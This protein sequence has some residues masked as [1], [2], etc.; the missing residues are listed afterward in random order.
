MSVDKL[1]AHRVLRSDALA[2]LHGRRDFENAVHVDHVVAKRDAD[3]G[4]YFPL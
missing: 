1:P 3:N 4:V 2:R